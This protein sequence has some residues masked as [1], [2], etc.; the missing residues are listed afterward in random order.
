MWSMSPDITWL[1]NSHSRKIQTNL[2]KSVLPSDKSQKSVIALYGPLLF[3]SLKKKRRLVA[4]AHALCRPVLWSKLMKITWKPNWHCFKR[5]L[6][7][8]TK[9]RLSKYTTS[10]T[11]SEMNIIE[12]REQKAQYCVWRM[13][14]RERGA[15]SIMKRFKTFA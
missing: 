15:I 3:S 13:N 11:G 8:S 4:T 14:V 6:Y 7:T 2:T 10:V 1:L 12:E 5:S 9:L